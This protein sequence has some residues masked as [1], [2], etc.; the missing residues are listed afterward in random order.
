MPQS[1][2][3]FDNFVADIQLDGK[4]VQLALWDTA[5]QEEYERLRPMSYAKAHVILIAFAVDTP[6]SLDN[7][8]NKWIEEVR[9]ICGPHVPVLLVGCKT[10]IREKARQSGHYIP[11]NFV[12]T[13][14]GVDD[15]FEAA[16]RAAMLVRE[17]AHGMTVASGTVGTHGRNGSHGG[18]RR[19]EAEK[20]HGKGC[21]VIC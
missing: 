7:V 20:G 18:K 15:I 2:T 3:V 11:D 17:G 5:G 9:S 1:P 12:E 10:D 13:A 6:D 14:E 4:P 19:G 21:C 16:T 8:A